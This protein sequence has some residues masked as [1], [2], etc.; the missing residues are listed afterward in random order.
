MIIFILIFIIIV[1]F[2]MRS[3][4]NI[5]RQ[6]VRPFYDDI[7]V[8]DEYDMKANNIEGKHED[9][10]HIEGKDDDSTIYYSIGPTPTTSVPSSSSELAVLPLKSRH[11]SSS[12]AVVPPISSSSGL[13]VRSLK[14]RQLSPSS[15]ASPPLSK[16]SRLAVRPLKSRKLPSSSAVASPLS[17]S[18]E[19]VDVT[20]LKSRK[21]PSSAVVSSSQRHQEQLK[22]NRLLKRKL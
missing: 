15:S 8:G 10:N 18:S 12:S 21:L 9:I 5:A 20:P 19:T 1:T 2:A 22:K 16:S 17:S 7:S 3:H 6:K 13:A 4:Q 14:S 11:L